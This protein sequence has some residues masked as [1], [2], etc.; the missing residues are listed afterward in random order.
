MTLD[1]VVLLTIIAAAFA[2]F[3]GGWLGA[4]LVALLVLAA[5]GLT[6]LVTPAEALSGFSSPAVVTVWAMFILSAALSRTGIAHQLGRPLQRFTRGSE[7]ALMTALMVAASLL[8]ALINTVTVA[9]VLLPAAMDLSRRSGRPP[10]RLLMPLALGSL[11]GGPFTGISTPPNI[12]ITDALRAAGLRPFGLFE[13][14]PIVAAVVVSGILYMALLG[15]RLLPRRKSG[16]AAEDSPLSPSYQLETHLFTTR[17]AGDSPLRGRTL[18]ESRIGSTLYLTVVALERRGKL[19]LAPRPTEVLEP[20]DLLIVHGRADHL[21]RLDG[22]QHLVIEPPGPEEELLSGRLFIA[23]AVVAA[24]SPLAGATLAASDLRRIHRVHCL[25]LPDPAGEGER[26][27]GR[28]VLEAGDRLLLQGERVSL[29]E[30]G[31]AGIVEELRFFSPAQA[32]MLAGWRARPLAVRVPAGSVLADRNLA[33]SRL[34]APYGLSV[35][36]IARAGELICMPAPEEKVLAA[37]LLLLQGSPHDLDALRGLQDLRIAAPSSSLVAELESQEIGITEVL[38]SPRTTLAGRT[39]AELL[40]REHYGLS[41]LAVWRRGR[42]HRTGLQYLPLQ[43]GDALLVYGRRKSL[44]ALA[45]DRDFLVL[46]KAAARTP[47]LEKARAAAAVM[48]GV[49]LAAL[50]GAVPISIAALA[51]A[52]LVVLLGCL[53]MEEAY[54]AIEWKVVFLIAGMLPLG[55]AIQK[56]GL[57]EMAAGAVI[58]A[59]GD[60]GPRA[61]VA[62]LFA[63]TVLFV[64]VVHPS[65]MAVLMAPVALSVAQS[66]GI[67]PHLLVMTVA[68]SASAS[69]ASPLS[70][71]AH[72]LVMGPGGYRFTDYVKV[73]VPL[74]LVVMTV[75]V[76]L[77]PVLWPP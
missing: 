44:E 64:Q 33:E 56:T 17:I 57:A 47:R 45:R 2:L 38:L 27:P 12:L 21:Q 67:S 19:I 42:A 32:H 41:V 71:P 75:A 5:L 7:L 58:G 22:G 25:D 55:L 14:T 11:L 8:S 20:G 51:G 70:H 43:F 66:T 24:H 26:D 77:L 59:V 62:S 52:A 48:L 50:S 1:V 37:D 28:R 34:A 29:E 23:E 53:R 9:A 31:R 6:G 40:F 72:Q 3:V 76:M 73:G 18:A 65:A 69:Y 13:F 36:G 10:G 49:I 74:T 60:L 39:L 4:D 35:V 46:D 30:I 15:R 63:V 61:I 54:R 16:A 68:V